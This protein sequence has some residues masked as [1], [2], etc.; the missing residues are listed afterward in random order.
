MGISV[1]PNFTMP[2]ASG[3]DTQPMPSRAKATDDHQLIR[4]ALRQSPA[5]AAQGA[6]CDCLFERYQPHLCS[7]TNDAV[8]NCKNVNL[9]SFTDVETFLAGKSTGSTIRTAHTVGKR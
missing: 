7:K 5:L 1:R 9:I 4:L 8:G 2:V 3:S 6:C